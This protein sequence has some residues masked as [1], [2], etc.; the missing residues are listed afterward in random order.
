VQVIADNNAADPTADLSATST[1][2]KAIDAATGNLIEPDGSGT[3]AGSVKMDCINNKVVYSI[4]MT[5][6][7]TSSRSCAFKDIT[8]D[9]TISDEAKL[10]LIAL[11]MAPDPDLTGDGIDTTYGSDQFYYNNGE[12][13]RCLFRGGRW[14]YGASAGVFGSYLNGPRSS[15]NAYFGGRCALAEW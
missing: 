15:T 11:T 4:N 8:C 14:D 3:T 7:A 1:E 13:E 10:L 5:N 2:W 12:A 6:K 9:S